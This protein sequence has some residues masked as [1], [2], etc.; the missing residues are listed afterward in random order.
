MAGP[1]RPRRFE[2]EAKPLRYALLA[3]WIV[4]ERIEAVAKVCVVRP[5][6]KP[7]SFAAF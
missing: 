7:Y 1:I 2:R 3:L 5:E 4:L 6:E